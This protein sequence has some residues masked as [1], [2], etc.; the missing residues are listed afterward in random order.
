MDEPDHSSIRRDMPPGTPPISVTQYMDKPMLSYNTYIAPAPTVN[1]QWDGSKQAAFVAEQPGSAATQM[2][3]TQ[4]KRGFGTPANKSGKSKEI[5]FVDE[6][7]KAATPRIKQ[8]SVPASPRAT[9]YTVLAPNVLI[10]DHFNESLRRYLATQEEELYHMQHAGSTNSSPRSL[11]VATPY[12][13]TG[14]RHSANEM[15]ILQHRMTR[16][17]SDP[18]NS[19]N[20][21]RKRQH[22]SRSQQYLNM[23]GVPDAT[24]SR[25][26]NDLQKLIQNGD[27]SNLLD[28]DPYQGVPPIV[29]NQLQVE[30]GNRRAVSAGSVVEPSS[31]RRTTSLS[32]LSGAGGGPVSG[33]PMN[34]FA[35]PVNDD[36]SNAPVHLGGWANTA[37]AY[38]SEAVGSPLAGD[39]SQPGSQQT[40]PRTPRKMKAPARKPDSK[41]TSKL[42]PAA[43][44]S[45]M[46]PKAAPT[47]Q[48]D[49]MA[50][51]MFTPSHEP[52]HESEKP[53]GRRGHVMMPKKKHGDLIDQRRASAPAWSHYTGPTIKKQMRPRPKTPPAK[54]GS[55]VNMAGWQ[56]EPQVDDLQ[57]LTWA[58]P[59]EDFDF[60]M[61]EQDMENLERFMSL[62]TE[63]N[64]LSPRISADF[65]QMS[66]EGKENMS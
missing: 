58:M 52:E 23:I 27:F 63:D 32:S 56:A 61:S 47:K 40:T 36:L 4:Q 6:T 62:E 20:A 53:K 15:E 41:L 64:P 49:L 46:M 22:T 42:E 10:D 48:Q 65:H 5:V 38:Q 35:L 45:D 44:W 25:S 7:A 13:N 43:P 2:L 39:G 33:G 17:G 57:N 21:L 14:R 59:D 30:G 66:I 11:G 31:F 55:D 51:L 9:E 54:T 34:S 29:Q 8:R 24:L 12:K 50:H 28:D 37:D 26:M 18:Y 3:R 19:A 16:R 60:V 1:F